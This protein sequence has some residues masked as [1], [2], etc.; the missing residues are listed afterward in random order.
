[1]NYKFLF[2]ITSSIIPF[3]VGS[4]HST[5][6]RFQQT[7]DTIRSIRERVTNSIIWITESS[8]KKLP[9]DYSS[10]LI[11]M[12]DYYVEHYDDVVIKQLYGNLEDSPERFD[13]CK[14]LLETRSLLNTFLQIRDLD[15]TRALKLSGRYIL[16]DQFNIG[17]YESEILNGYY[18]MQ[19]HKMENDIYN[20]L[21]GIDGQI[22]TGFWSFDKSLLYETIEMYQKCFSY[23]DM[24]MSYTSGVDIEHSIYK[25][26][27]HAKIIKVPIL[28]VNRNH[29]PTGEV[30]SI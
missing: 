28:G 9:Q 5:Q 6:E 16:N 8:S 21:Y 10:K 24:M 7:L 2:I 11:E 15:F 3:R 30:Y 20:L 26:I 19:V 23:M 18:V 25:W 13:F 14:S 17:N 4:V 22:T 29:G 27:D 1:M 12:S